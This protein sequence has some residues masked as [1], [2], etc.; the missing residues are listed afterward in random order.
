MRRLNIDRS[1][2]ELSEIASIEIGRTPSRAVE[3][4]WE[5]EQHWLS[6]ADFEH[7][8]LITSTK[9]KITRSAIRECG[10]RIHDTGTLVMS[11]KLT[12]GKIGIL[13]APMATNEA[14][15]AIKPFSAERIDQRYLFHCLS[16]FDYTPFLDRASKGK[17]L[18]KAK[19]ARLR[20]AFPTDVKEQ[21]RIAAVLDK[22]DAIRRNREQALVLA[23]D[24]LRSVFLEMF[25]DP[26][27]NSKGLPKQPLAKFGKIMTGNTPPRSDL[28][29][30][31]HAIEW[32]KSDNVNTGEHFLT[33]AV[34]G[35][36][37]K[38]RALGRIATKRSQYL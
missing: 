20:I 23:D 33:Q 38:G 35:L 3:R 19:L 14:I 24:F 15:A 21:R 18:N 2:A 16:S 25:G 7:G 22:S 5:G 37:E 31:G 13:G 12:I 27:V 11:F 29:N 26:I 10:I 30:F 1:V 36:S 34:E 9:E 28:K 8:D 4:Y 6:I 17:T 32:I